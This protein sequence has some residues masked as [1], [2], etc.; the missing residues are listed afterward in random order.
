MQN[1]HAQTHKRNVFVVKKKKTKQSGELC[2]MTRPYR[3]NVFIQLFYKLHQRF[4]IFDALTTRQE[5]NTFN[6]CS[7]RS[8]GKRLDTTKKMT[9]LHFTPQSG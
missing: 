7:H 1:T 5:E 9:E 2:L 6:L 4:S 3:E 8:D